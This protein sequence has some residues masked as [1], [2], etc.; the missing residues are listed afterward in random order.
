MSDDN[1]DEPR[2]PI[3]DWDQYYKD[4]GTEEL[5][6]Y[7]TTPDPEVIEA[8]KNYCAA[9]PARVLDLG[10]GPGTMAIGFARMGYDVT[11]CDISK[12]AL[13]VAKSRAGEEG[14]ADSITFVVCDVRESIKGTFDI[15]N[16]R[17]CFH[18]MRGVEIQMY[19]DNISAVMASG[20]VLLLKTFS[21]D[22]PGEEGPQR[23]SAEDIEEVFSR[24]FEMVF[25]TDT[26]FQS[27]MDT[28]PKAILTV[29][30]RSE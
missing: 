12:T 30:K 26:V 1:K 10:T 8:L 20:S 4:T 7:S 18:I 15:V 16:D 23:Y 21:K 25:S 17:G 24:S 27:T 6:W 28:D 5:P 3:E 14:V 11:A 19:L 22:E 9:A 29:L 13:K 2:L